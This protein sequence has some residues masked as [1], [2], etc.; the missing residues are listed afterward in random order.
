MLAS[1]SRLARRQLAAQLVDALSKDIKPGSQ[2]LRLGYSTTSP[3]TAYVFLVLPRPAYLATYEEY[4]EA[5]QAMLLASCKVA[6][7]RATSAA[8]IIGIAT[9]PGGTR[10]ASQDLLL[11]EVDEAHWGPEQDEEAHWIQREIG[12][13]LDER[14]KYT[15][16]RD[17]EYPVVA[18]APSKLSPAKRMQE[19]A[20]LRRLANIKSRS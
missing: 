20:R 4:R 1:E 3:D 17:N 10:G 7:L 9:E 13:L 16:R 6:R 14:V 5:R 2:F 15:E 8:R 12:I 11:I 19:R 18:T